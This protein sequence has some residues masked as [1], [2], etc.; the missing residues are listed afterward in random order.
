[1]TLG[2]IA[3]IRVGVHWSVFAIW[4]LLAWSLSTEVL[5]DAAPG[6][7]RGTYWVTAALAALVLL[8]CLLAHELSHALVA[9]R[10][11]VATEAITLWVFGGVAQLRGE[12]PTPST[13]LRIAAAGPAASFGLAAAAGIV[14]GVLEALGASDLATAAVSWL[15]TVNVVLAVFNLLPGFPLDGGRVLHAWL[16]RRSGDRLAA[17]RR[18]A[19]VGRGF[20]YG[21]IGLGVL[22][23][24]SG[25]W[26]GLWL[27]F[28]GWFLTS[29][30]TA[31]SEQGGLRDALADVRVLDVM[32]PDPDTA[33]DWI[34]VQDLLDGYVLR[35]RH[36]TFPVYDRHRTLSGLATLA[37]IKSVPPAKR[38]STP[39]ST[40]AVP[41]ADVPA[42]GPGELLLDLMG[43]SPASRHG[44]VL[45]FD[46]PGGQLVGIVTPSDVARAVEYAALHRA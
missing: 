37:G 23:F 7:S 14:L 20:G 2:R 9:R 44:R 28:I 34:T 8:G 32:T 36:S 16:W 4:W 3:G 15:V 42:T 1:M 45:V 12:A 10:H 40:I 33:P 31:E 29:A 39:V 17:T 19:R 22:E 21:L 43:R 18:A 38:S 26:S 35:L 5:P 13:E 27:V 24:T 46:H 6:S 41:I 25:Y 11:G 30:A